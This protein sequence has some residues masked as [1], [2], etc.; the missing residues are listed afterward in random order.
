[1]T[2]S[3]DDSLLFAESAPDPNMLVHRGAPWRVLVVDDDQDIHLITALTLRDVQVDGRPIAL[4]RADSAAEARA[5]FANGGAFAVA[6]V[7]VVMETPTAGLELVRWV[8]DEHRDTAVRLLLR[9]G[10]PGGVTERRITQE[11]DLH[12]YVAKANT[13]GRDLIS[14]IVGAIRAWRDIQ[15]ARASAQVARALL[16]A[17]ADSGPLPGESLYAAARGLLAPPRGLVQRHDPAAAPLGADRCAPLGDGWELH[18]P[19]GAP[20]G[21]EEQSTLAAYAHELT[22]IRR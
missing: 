14:R 2:H 8:R 1:M 20:F 10:H 9:T 12:D 15:A 13:T 21:L 19:E 11:Y 5:A 18:A 17:L 22:T 7:D 4:V 16:R 3:V 6:L